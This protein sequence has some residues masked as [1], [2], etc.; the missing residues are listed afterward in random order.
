MNI[1]TI[2]NKMYKQFD[3]KPYSCG[4]M[5]IND[6]I[7]KAYEEGKKDAAHN[8]HLGNKEESS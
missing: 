4:R 1:R 3:M 7:N 5:F 8:V 6:A 2:K